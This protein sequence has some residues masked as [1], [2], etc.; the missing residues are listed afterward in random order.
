MSMAQFW[1]V[2]QLRERLSI[3]S[4]RGLRAWGWHASLR[5]MD[6]EEIPLELAEG[7]RAVFRTGTWGNRRVRP[8]EP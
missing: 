3:L 2:G 6:R 7:S 1:A 5:A 8:S 4:R